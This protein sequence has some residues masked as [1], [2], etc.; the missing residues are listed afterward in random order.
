MIEGQIAGF[1]DTKTI[2]VN[3]GVRD[4]IDN[5]HVCLI[6]EGSEIYALLSPREIQ[7]K[8]TIYKTTWVAKNFYLYTY[9]DPLTVGSSVSL[10]KLNRKQERLYAKAIDT[11]LRDLV[12]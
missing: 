9:V 7:E 12:G 8:M 1:L 3:R 11:V 6:K 5:G 10:V 2:V 4:G